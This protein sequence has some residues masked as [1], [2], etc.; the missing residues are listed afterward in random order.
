MWEKQISMEASPDGPIAC[1][2]TDTENSTDLSDVPHPATWQQVASEH[3]RILTKCVT[4]HGG[5]PERTE[6][7]SFFATFATT[8]A[9]LECAVAIQE[10]LHQNGK[11]RL[12]VVTNGQ[13]HSVK[14]RIGAGSLSRPPDR[15]G[16]TDYG[17]RAR[18]DDCGR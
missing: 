18:R 11:P 3:D 17:L 1:L 9:A 15:A 8:K 10:A 13:S 7:D 12:S 16:A 2:F 4:R 6:G 5:T 14:V